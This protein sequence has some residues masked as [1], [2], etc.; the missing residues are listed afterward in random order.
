MRTLAI[1]FAASCSLI[2]AGC[3]AQQNA[4]RERWG[5]AL[6]GAGSALQ[7]SGPAPVELPQQRTVCPQDG[8]PCQSF[9]VHNH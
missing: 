2:V 8:G 1:L 3:T 6:Q 5:N 7:A 4:A 9:I